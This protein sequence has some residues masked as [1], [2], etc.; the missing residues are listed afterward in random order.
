M[1]LATGEEEAED[2][3]LV[4]SWPLTTAVLLAIAECAPAWPAGRPAA[5][6]AVGVEEVD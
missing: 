3:A 5:G 4:G 2:T 1:D 6:V